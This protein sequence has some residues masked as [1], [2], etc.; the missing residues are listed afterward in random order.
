M[1]V[2]FFFQ[3]LKK[4][5][6]LRCTSCFLMSKCVLVSSVAKWKRQ[7]SERQAVNVWIPYILSQCSKSYTIYKYK[8]FKIC[9]RLPDIPDTCYASSSLDREITGN[10]RTGSAPG[11]L[12]TAC[13]NRPKKLFLAGFASVATNSSQQLPPTVHN[14]CH[15]SQKFTTAATNSSQQFAESR[16]DMKQS[17]AAGLKT[18]S[19]NCN[20]YCRPLSVEFHLPNV[21]RTFVN[22]E[23]S[24]LECWGLRGSVCPLRRM[25]GRTQS[26]YCQRPT[27]SYDGDDDD[28]NPSCHLQYRPCFVFFWFLCEK[29]FLISDSRIPAGKKVANC[30]ANLPRALYPSFATLSWWWWWWSSWWRLLWWWWRWWHSIWSATQDR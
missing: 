21:F 30:S 19:T 2:L 8:L 5:V 25:V 29:V 24:W 27:L 23:I 28:Y 11:K 15:S 26:L 7:T 22:C 10:Q 17:A 16:P 3:R 4:T 1:T 20:Q 6:K 12:P 18:V 13:G 9:P 14:S